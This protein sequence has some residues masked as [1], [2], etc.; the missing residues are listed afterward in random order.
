[1]KSISDVFKNMQTFSFLVGMS[2]GAALGLIL[3]CY[4]VPHG[5]KAIAMFRHYAYH[6]RGQEKVAEQNRDD[7]N[8]LYAD[9]N[10]HTSGMNHDMGTANPYIMSSV[11]SERQFLQ[12]MTLHHQAAVIMAQQVLSL[13]NLHMEVKDLANTII[14]AQTSEIASMKVWMATWK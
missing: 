6:M 12:D 2:F 3:F 5:P 13:P 8:A 4:M 7:F 11:T 14:R 9:K 10:M 1:M